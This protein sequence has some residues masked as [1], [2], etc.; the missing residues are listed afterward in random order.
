[1]Y[2]KPEGAGTAVSLTNIGYAGLG[3]PIPY[4]AE[5]G[6]CGAVAIRGLTPN[7]SY[8]SWPGGHANGREGCSRNVV[9]LSESMLPPFWQ[10]LEML[11]PS[12]NVKADI[13]SWR[14][15]KHENK[16]ANSHSCWCSRES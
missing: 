15:Q 2:G 3:V 13:I 11:T 12:L 8:V 5:T 9:V 4:N 16:R 10:C 6:V 7:E 14:L 1:M